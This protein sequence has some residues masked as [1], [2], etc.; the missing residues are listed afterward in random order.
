MG[1]QQSISSQA[2][3]LSSD[4]KC[5]EAQTER[6]GVVPRMG[7]HQQQDSREEHNETAAASPAALPA[8]LYHQICVQPPES[9]GGNAMSWTRSLQ[10]AAGA[11]GSDQVTAAAAA[12]FEESRSE[13]RWRRLR[14]F[15]CSG[16]P[17]LHKVQLLHGLEVLCKRLLFHL[18]KT[19]A[20]APKCFSVCAIAIDNL[21]DA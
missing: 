5:D 8:A 15:T 13:W 10:P 1:M 7:E 18:V 12:M 21:S 11:F 6:R 2:P 19:G 17:L 3:F 16:T 9:I 14:L 4:Q 20:G